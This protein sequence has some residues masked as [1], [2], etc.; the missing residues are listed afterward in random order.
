M[1]ES[2]PAPGGT[3]GICPE[4]RPVGNGLRRTA[5]LRMDR[6]RQVRCV[7]WSRSVEPVSSDACMRAG[8]IERGPDAVINGALLLVLPNRTGD[9]H[10]TSSRQRVITSIA[11]TRARRNS[12]L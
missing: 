10:G 1:G 2:R 7:P 5:D 8:L 6:V 12:S 4:A 9:I 11:R 3:W